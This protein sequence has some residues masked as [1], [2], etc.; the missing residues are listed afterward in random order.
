V[1]VWFVIGYVVAGLFFLTWLW[2]ARLNAEMLCSARHRRGR[3][4]VIGSW[5]CPVV[6]LWFPFMIVDDVYRA[7]RPEATGYRPA[8]TGDSPDLLDLR[9]VPGSRVLGLWWGLWLVSALL[10]RIAI[11]I[12][13]NAHSV[14]SILRTG[15]VEIF[16]SAATI[17]A[18]VALILVVR[19]IS[20][21]QDRAMW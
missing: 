14:D 16:E 1:S 13:N 3:G 17:G 2:Q 19:R 6:N 20:G 5:I 12:W 21:W 9:A 10:N 4:W 8:G 15:V 11:S 7:S 18:G